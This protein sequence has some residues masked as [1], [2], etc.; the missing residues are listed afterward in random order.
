MFQQTKPADRSKGVSPIQV[1]IPTTDSNVLSCAAI[2]WFLNASGGYSASDEFQ[3]ADLCPG[4][5]KETNASR[6]KTNR[7]YL[8]LHVIKREQPK[9]ASV[10][11]VIE[12]GGQELYSATES[13]SA[14]G[15]RLGYF[16]YRIDVTK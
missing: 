1:R 13:L 2:L 14:D 5:A 8:E 15:P 6:D 16:E 7:Y 4:P 10:R 9:V 12:H 11:V 3:N